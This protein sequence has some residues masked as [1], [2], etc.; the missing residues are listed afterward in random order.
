MICGGLALLALDGIG[1]GGWLGL[2]WWVVVLPLVGAVLAGVNPLA[3][4]KAREA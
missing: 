4:R 2:R 3:R 1:G